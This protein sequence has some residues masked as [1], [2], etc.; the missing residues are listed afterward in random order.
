MADPEPGKNSSSRNVKISGLRIEGA[1]GKT[2][3]VFLEDGSLFLF[4]ASSAAAVLA[5]EIDAAGGV[6]DENALAV[7]E[8]AHNDWLCRRKALE[9]LNRAEQYRRGLT[10]SRSAV[11]K[12][13]S[14]KSSFDILRFLPQRTL[15]FLLAPFPWQIRNL[16]MVATSLEQPIWWY[17][18]PFVIVGFLFLLRNKHVREFIPLLVYAP[19]LTLLFSVVQGNMGTAYRMRIQ[20]L[21]FYLMMAAVGLAS[22]KAKRLGLPQEY[23]FSP[24]L[25]EKAG[26]QDV[27][28]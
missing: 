20:V 8:A 25:R 9:L 22:H 10:I 17:L 28:G 7:F 16:R 26:R 19:V 12:E 3:R 14:Y 2:L 27:A 1:E 24:K 23:L 11:H 15:T 13:H 5:G 18:F 21:P 4:S 6:A